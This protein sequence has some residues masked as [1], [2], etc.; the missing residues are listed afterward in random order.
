MQKSKLRGKRYLN[1]FYAP[2]RKL[3][4][5]LQKLNEKTKKHQ[6]N[7]I[8]TEHQK[9]LIIKYARPE[10]VEKGFVFTRQLST[11]N[12][13]GKRGCRPGFMRSGLR[14]REKSCGKNKTKHTKKH[15]RE[16]IKKKDLTDI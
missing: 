9:F 14:E 5:F 3:G 10:T 8:K 1:F 4:N 15:V 16:M 11:Q 13:S 2:L 12:R 6:Y 7:E